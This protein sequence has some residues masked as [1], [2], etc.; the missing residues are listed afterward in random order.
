MKKIM[1]SLFALCIA[2]SA[3]GENLRSYTQSKDSEKMSNM[4]LDM[5]K[6]PQ[7]GLYLMSTDSRYIVKGN[8]KIID[9]FNGE[10]IDSLKRLRETKNNV[11]LSLIGVDSAQLA[12]TT[13]GK[14]DAPSGSVLFF[15]PLSSNSRPLLERIERLS[16]KGQYVHIVP[17]PTPGNSME[18]INNVICGF[19]NQPRE[20]LEKL[21]KG[22]KDFE[23]CA[24]Q[25][26]LM[27]SLLV[28]AILAQGEMPMAITSTGRLLLGKA[29]TQFD[30]I[31]ASESL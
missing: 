4:G 15:N 27:R 26:N 17:F 12:S 5:H 25:E 13:L 14:I 20:T 7:H 16:S 30:E 10:E 19:Q 23:T 22:Q 21:L 1:I 9:R 31:V 3:V 18:E 28:A 2:T 11:D 29:A 24:V 8:F 6:S